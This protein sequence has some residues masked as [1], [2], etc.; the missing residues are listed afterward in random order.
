ML[1][2][3][4]AFLLCRIKK[5]MMKKIG[6]TIPKCHACSHYELNSEQMALV[7]MHAIIIADLLVPSL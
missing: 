2:I 7:C 3:T 1:F 5:V 6:A 4:C